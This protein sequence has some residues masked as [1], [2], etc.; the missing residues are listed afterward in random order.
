MLG[1]ADLLTD[2]ARLTAERAKARAIQERWEATIRL[3]LAN[4]YRAVDIAR[5]AGVT[6]QRVYQI[7]QKP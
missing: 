3:A 1:V 6:P 4:D 2:L 5:A 7:G